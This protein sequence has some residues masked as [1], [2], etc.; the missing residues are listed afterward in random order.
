MQHHYT[1]SSSHALLRLDRHELCLE[2]VY[3]PGQTP[4]ALTVVWNRGDETDL[5]VD[6]VRQT[7]PTNALLPLTTEQIFLVP[8]ALD[9][10]AWQFNRDFYC[11]VDHDEEVS[12]VGLVFYG[13]HHAPVLLNTNEA[14]G[15][16]SLLTMFVEEFETR[17]LR[18]GEMLRVLLR[19]LLIKLTRLLV[20]RQ[21]GEQLVPEAELGL[22]RRF[23][24]L[25]E[26]HFR[27][28]HSVA[29]YAE[30][31][32]KSAKTLSNLFQEQHQKSPLQIIHERIT[33]EAK[34]L[35]VYTDRPVKEIAFDLGFTDV[36]VFHRFFK[37][38][39]GHSPSAFKA[40]FRQEM[41]GQPH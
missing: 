10:V 27:E 11:I 7:L 37:N 38:Q 17:D 35:L 22:I 6:G 13:T 4:R 41:T 39:A 2:R 19:R 5:Y 12:C 1:E 25:V 31:L 15:F 14:E 23:N 16:E 8:N 18:Q 24:W 30:L 28:K 32:N 20:G 34:R 36:S 3:Q 29:Q 21:F 40:A 26:E 9:V 33:T